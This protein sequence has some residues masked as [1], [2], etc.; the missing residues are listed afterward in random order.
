MPPMRR[1]RSAAR[2][3]RRP[4]PPPAFVLERA[5]V[6]PRLAL[7]GG[8]PLAIRLRFRAPAPLDL[9]VHVRTPGGKVMRRWLIRSAAPGPGAAHLGRAHHPP[10]GGA[11]R[12]LPRG[13]RARSAGA[14]AAPARSTGAGTSTPCAARTGSAARSGLFGVP[15]NG[16]RTHEGFDINAVL[17]HAGGRGPRRRGEGAPLRPG[18]LREPRDR[19]RPARAARLLVLAPR[20]ARP[21]RAGRACAHGQVLG[22]V[23]ATGNARSVG[24]HLH[25][26]TRGPG[27]PFDPLPQLV[28]VGPL[29]LMRRPGHARGAWRR[30]SASPSAH[31]QR[32]AV[33]VSVRRRRSRAA[34]G[35]GGAG[36][37]RVTR[38]ATCPT[39]A[40]RP[41]GSG[42]SAGDL[43]C[44][45]G[46]RAPA[47]DRARGRSRRTRSTSCTEGLDPAT[48]STSA[49]AARTGE[50]VMVK[51]DRGSLLRTAPCP[52]PGRMERAS[53]RSPAPDG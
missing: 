19:P 18:A 3:R 51:H 45:R 50:P 36:G 41:G 42:W 32:R 14:C 23:G 4:P 52:P 1:S 2:S 10:P 38:F 34:T 48:P 35:E 15:R 22:G 46:P 24:C 21:R 30:A 29:E 44:A 26:E 11:R 37:G 43:R 12:A 7:F 28:H 8:R 6:G 5:A 39:T 47:G 27:G 16:G 31:R 20:R 9:K 13:G 40:R 33:A 53:P 17:R 49:A 25:F